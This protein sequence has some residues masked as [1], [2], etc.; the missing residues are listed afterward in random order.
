MDRTIAFVAEF[1]DDRLVRGRIFD[2]RDD[3]IAGA[4]AG[5]GAD[6]RPA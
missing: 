1:R 4:H 3:A 2:A 5:H 6:R